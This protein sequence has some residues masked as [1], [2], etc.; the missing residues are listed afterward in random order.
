MTTLEDRVTELER[1][2]AEFKDLRLATEIRLLS[3]DH[4]IK[5]ATDN[6][7]AHLVE[8]RHLREALDALRT[9]VRVGFGTVRVGQETIVGMLNQ[10]V[11]G[12]DR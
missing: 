9:E 6:D 8:L 12:N 4:L 2:L 11:A 7:R 5:A 10:L 1:Q 3:Q